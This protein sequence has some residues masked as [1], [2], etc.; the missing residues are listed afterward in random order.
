MDDD[1]L[2]HQDA[3]MTYRTP[4]LEAEDV[5]NLW[6]TGFDTT[7]EAK[8]LHQHLAPVVKMPF[9]RVVIWD[10]TTLNQPY[11]VPNGSYQ[12]S[13]IYAYAFNSRLVMVGRIKPPMGSSYYLS[14]KV[15]GR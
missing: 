5:T 9:G 4:I 12:L 13:A 2:S 11:L 15:S 14:T 7:K 8:V 1:I 10:I 6:L 3:Y